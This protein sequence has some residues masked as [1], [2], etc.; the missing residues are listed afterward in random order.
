MYFNTVYKAAVMTKAGEDSN[1]KWL[2]STH[3]LS[4]PLISIQTFYM[5]LYLF[6]KGWEGGELSSLLLSLTFE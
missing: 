3:L 2:V 5:S 1:R 6:N 4:P